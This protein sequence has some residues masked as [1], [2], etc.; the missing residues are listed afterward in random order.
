MTLDSIV[1]ATLAEFGLDRSQLR[2]KVRA[3]EVVLARQLIAIL[4]RRHTTLSYPQ[5]AE[6]M[7]KARTSHSFVMEAESRGAAR[8]AS[9]TVLDIPSHQGQRI[10]A[11]IKSIERAAREGT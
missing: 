8:V 5:I 10:T 6:G 11:V 2:A 9:N 3:P 1:K 4:A 7:G